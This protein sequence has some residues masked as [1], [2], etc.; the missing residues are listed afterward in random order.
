MKPDKMLKIIKDKGIL[1]DFR[2]MV[3]KII[4]KIT[5]SLDSLLEEFDVE[6]DKPELQE[7]VPNGDGSDS[8]Q[9]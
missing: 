6:D 3:K 7:V 1:R 2:E 4:P 5:E 9:K 8:N